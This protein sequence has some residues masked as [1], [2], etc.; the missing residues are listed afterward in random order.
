[1]MNPDSDL[2]PLNIKT[3]RDTKRTAMLD[4]MEEQEQESSALSNKPRRIK[5]EAGHTWNIR[6][7]P[8]Q[9]GP[10]RM[11]FVKIAQHWVN[12]TPVYCPRFTPKAFG[13]DPNAPCPL[14]EAAADL[15][16]SPD[17]F[18]NKL[19]YKTKCT[20][21]YRTW[22]LVFDT[23]DAKG[24]IDE[25]PMS[26]ILN[27]WEFDMS[28]STWDD[29][30]KFQ[31]WA[32]SRGVK[33]GE[34][35]SEYGIMDLETGTNLLATKGN[36]GTTLERID[37]GPGPIFEV[38]GATWDEYLAKVFKLIREPKV[39]F[40][41]ESVL[42]DLAEKVRE[43]ADR[44]EEGPSARRGTRSRYTEDNDDAVAH[45]PARRSRFSGDDEAAE[46]PARSSRGSSRTEPAHHT[47]DE[48]AEEAPRPS[49][50][51]SAP[52]QEEEAAP[53]APRR[54][55]NVPPPRRQAVKQ[56]ELP[57]E[58]QVPDAEVPRSRVKTQAETEEDNAPVDIA[59]RR[60]APA[61]IE[62]AAPRRRTVATPEPESAPEEG[63][64]ETLPPAR[65]AATYEPA[66]KRG[67]AAAPRGGV[68]EE[69]DNAPE[70]AN[71]P[72]PA[73]REEVEEAP[74]AVNTKS[75][76]PVR[77]AGGATDLLRGRLN[78]LQSKG[79]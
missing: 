15:D 53:V 43:T 70:E 42:F 38:T 61:S 7:L 23:E 35:P 12:K 39:V 4:Y 54:S 60:S 41:K 2:N 28:P 77:S 1:M 58:D 64:E 73:T 59:P 25:M 40:S 31:K 9:V 11:P 57:E 17:D 46:A 78:S 21:R 19:A 79:R 32:A 69:E 55:S 6:L 36:K 13:G 24:N 8:V 10:D 48:P 16:G 62:P 45:P 72:A 65:S 47:E 75:P 27:P 50:R 68:D 49:S 37:S 76:A 71:D 5:I 63:A 26:E 56:E 29:F 67:P 44:G 51:R 3:M 18:V 34:T 74:P 30:K 22:S 66:P 20:L 14:C 52:V 33:A